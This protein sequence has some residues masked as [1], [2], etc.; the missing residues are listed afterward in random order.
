[1]KRIVRD[2]GQPDKPFSKESVGNAGQDDAYTDDMGV[3]TKIKT[4]REELKIAVA[5][6]AN[7]VGLSRQT[8]YDLER[9]KQTSTTKLHLLCKVL[10]LNPDWVEYG[11]GPRLMLSPTN[12][13]DTP[14][15]KGAHLVQKDQTEANVEGVGMAGMARE[16]LEV[17][18]LLS[19]LPEDVR[20]PVVSMIRSLSGGKPAKEDDK[21]L[22]GTVRSQMDQRK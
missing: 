10:G 3:G 15:D 6:L 12:T 2:T 13:V 18:L 17:A 21:E 14:A 5:E 9:E 19:G 4:R 11:R 20:G 16:V 7:Q 8:L 22:P 1:M